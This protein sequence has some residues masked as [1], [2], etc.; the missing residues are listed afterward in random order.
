M[1]RFAHEWLSQLVKF[2]VTFAKGETEMWGCFCIKYL[3]Q[4]AID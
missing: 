1:T 2:A 4:R 3:V